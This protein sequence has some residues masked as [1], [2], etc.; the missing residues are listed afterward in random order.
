METFSASQALCEENPSVT[1][2]FPSQ[3]ACD[4]ELC[5]FYLWSAP[6]QTIEQT[7]ETPVIWNVL[8]KGQWRAKCF[9]LM[10][11]SW[12]R[13]YQNDNTHCHQYMTVVVLLWPFHF[14]NFE[15]LKQ[16]ICWFQR[17][18]PYLCNDST[19][20]EARCL[21]TKSREISNT[22]NLGLKLSDCSE[23]L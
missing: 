19:H 17:H 22:R 14:F 10:M 5:F 3:K 7:I 23:I 2:G 4:A 21:T 8:T 16:R 9:H 6:E 1:G 11:A 15:N 18:D 13:I 12:W 20:F